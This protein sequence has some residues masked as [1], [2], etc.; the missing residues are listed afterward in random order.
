[1]ASSRPLTQLP[2]ALS[3]AAYRNPGYRALYEAAR[4]ARIPAHQSGGTLRWMYD[5]ADLS[6]IADAMGLAHADAA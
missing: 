4:D 2:R 5:P 3:E 6:K 1:M